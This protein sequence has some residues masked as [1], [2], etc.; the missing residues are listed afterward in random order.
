M[1]CGVTK[2]IGG[3]AT[4]TCDNAGTSSHT[5]LH[6]GIVTFSSWFRVWTG[7]RVYWATNDA[8]PGRYKTWTVGDGTL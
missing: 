5:G 3:A 8:T 2:S 1:A 4:A 7:V 6:S